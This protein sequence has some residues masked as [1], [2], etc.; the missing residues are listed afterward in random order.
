MS[1]K[2]DPFLRIKAVEEISGFHRQSLWRKVKQG[3]FPRPI[4][5]GPVNLWRQSQIIEWQRSLEGRSE[6]G[7][8]RE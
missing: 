4:K 5:D 7:A 6:K 1:Q 2:V 3:K 8:L